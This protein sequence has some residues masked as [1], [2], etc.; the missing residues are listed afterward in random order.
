M[1]TT[2]ITPTVSLVNNKPAVTSLKIA[3]HFGKRHEQVLRSI[4]STS[5]DCPADFSQHNFV[6]AVYPDEQGKPR[7]MFA[8]HRD[9]FMLLV[10]GYAGK[11]A[12]EIKL[13]YIAAFNAMEAK[14]L[15]KPLQ[16]DAPATKEQRTP[17]VNLVNA[18]ISVAPLSYRDAWHMVHA[19]SNGKKAKELTFAEVQNA[20]VFVQN[21]IDQYCVSAKAEPVCL[22]D[23]QARAI[24]LGI[25]SVM[26]IF[27]PF[28]KQFMD[29]LGVARALLGCSPNTGIINKNFVRVTTLEQDKTF[30]SE[31]YSQNKYSVAQYKGN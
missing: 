24:L 31:A 6:S 9:G 18:L 11:K 1:A 30:S 16:L 13:A 21:K 12:L 10:M 5:A 22:P 26:G 25:Y 20:L 19:H 3:E 23:Q 14:L 7:P 27:H 4:R 2:S 8:I 15:S 17:L 28:S 29:L